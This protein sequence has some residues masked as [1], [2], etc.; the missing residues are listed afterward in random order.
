[1]R[2]LLATGIY[3]PESGGPATFVPALAADWQKHGIE[4]AVVT[5]GDERTERSSACDVEVVSRAG[6]AFVRYVRFALRVWRAARYMKADVV[7]LQGAFSEGLPGTI[8]AW[9]AGRP[10]VLR[11]PG[12]FAWES[13]QRETSSLLALEAFLKSSKPIKWRVIFW[14]ESLVA[15]HA[16][17]VIAPSRYLEQLLSAWG[18]RKANQHVIYNTVES[19]PA[20]PSRTETRSAL[21]FAPG[22]RVLV[23]VARAV[24]WKRVDFLLDVLIRLPVTH[25]LVVLGDGPELDHWKALAKQAQLAARVRFEGR[26]SHQDVFRYLHAADAFVLPSLYEGL[27]HVALE[28]AC[29]GRP[30]FLSDRGGNPEAQAMFPDRIR[31]LPYAQIDV[32]VEAL[33]SLPELLLPISPVPFAHVA[34]AYADTI[35]CATKTSL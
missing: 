18:V 4:I 16:T 32:W 13:M 1:M 21:A 14:L 6:G 19:A 3:P 33:T 17:A 10:T 26:V 28:A 20:L 11:V 35:K 2:V 15:R 7:F 8:G 34:E 23:C 30:C 12:D 27:P 25:Q 22:A 29:L 9:L 5:Y 31:I 24:P